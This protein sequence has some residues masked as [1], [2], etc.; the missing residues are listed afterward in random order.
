M[1]RGGACLCWAGLRR[2]LQALG[3]L[4]RA[5]GVPE[6]SPGWNPWCGLGL[7]AEYQTPLRA[8][9]WGPSRG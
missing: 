4:D 8:D 5:E 3:S 7:L 6:K 1:A 2:A 9:L